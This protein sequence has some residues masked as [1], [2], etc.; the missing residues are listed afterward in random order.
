MDVGLEPALEILKKAKEKYYV[1][2]T[3]DRAQF[4]SMLG[5]VTVLFAKTGSEE[6]WRMFLEWLDEF[7]KQK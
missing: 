7:R 3:C 4:N 1:L 2:K 6:E 5:N